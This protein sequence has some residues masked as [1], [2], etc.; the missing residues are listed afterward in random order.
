MCAH[1]AWPHDADLRGFERKSR[2]ARYGGG[3]GLA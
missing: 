2:G 3:D 1:L